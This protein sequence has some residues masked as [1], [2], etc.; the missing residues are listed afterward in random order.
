[1]KGAGLF[2]YFRSVAVVNPRIHNKGV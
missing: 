1:M 2:V